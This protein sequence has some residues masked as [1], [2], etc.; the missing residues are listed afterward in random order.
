MKLSYNKAEVE[1]SI[2]A[3]VA[4]NAI[5]NELKNVNSIHNELRDF[6]DISNDDQTSPSPVHT[7]E[8]LIYTAK[9]LKKA[10]ALSHWCENA[11]S[12]DDIIIKKD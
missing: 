10:I 3:D 9:R 11:K 5:F 12:R 2:I 7:A 6:Y 1:L 8:N 4:K